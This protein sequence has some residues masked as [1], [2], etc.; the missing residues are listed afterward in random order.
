MS[1][2][3]LMGI[4]YLC[5]TSISGEDFGHWVVMNI[6]DYDADYF[7]SFGMHPCTYNFYHVLNENCDDN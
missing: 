5:N 4:K 3:I 2:Y 6:R 1:Q 7:D